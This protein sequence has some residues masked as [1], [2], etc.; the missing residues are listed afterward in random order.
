MGRD[1]ELHST[2]CLHTEQ[3]AEFHPVCVYTCIHLYFYSADG[4]G[5]GAVLS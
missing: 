1:E 4:D 5:D 2:Q 3:E